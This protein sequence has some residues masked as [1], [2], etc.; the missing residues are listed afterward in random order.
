[1]AQATA[2]VRSLAWNT[3]LIASRWLF[4]PS[5]RNSLEVCAASAMAPLSG[6]V[7]RITVVGGRIAQDVERGLKAR[8][9]QLQARMRPQAGGAAIVAGKEPCPR[10]GQGPSSRKVCPVGAVSKTMWL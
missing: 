7:T 10:L 6:R 8:L 4:K 1:M 2:S 5:S 9:L 3:P